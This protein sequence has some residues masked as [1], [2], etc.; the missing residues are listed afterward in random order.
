[1]LAAGFDDYLSKPVNIAKMESMLIKYL[2]EEKVR[3]NVPQAEE[4]LE[5]EEGDVLPPQIFAVEG[6]DP[7]VGIDCCGNPED[8]MDAVTVFSMSVEKKAADIERAYREK[9]LKNFIILVHSLKSTSRIIVATK[10]SELAF[11]LEMAGK[12]GDT[13]NLYELT[14]RLL[15]TYRKLSAPLREIVNAW[16]EKS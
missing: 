5:S 6:I 10:L 1:M 12:A 2:P 8:Y 7:F 14:P 9:D 13:K 3:L 4:P 15:E 16:E 11:E